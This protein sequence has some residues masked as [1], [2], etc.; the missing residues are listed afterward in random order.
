MAYE[1]TLIPIW[2]LITTFVTSAIT[3]TSEA[4]LGDYQVYIRPVPPLS[5]YDPAKFKQCFHNQ[6]I[7]HTL[8]D[9]ARNTR[10]EFD[11]W[12]P[13]CHRNLH[14]W[15]PVRRPRVEPHFGRGL[16]FLMMLRSGPTG[17]IQGLI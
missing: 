14:M 17:W 1:G 11:D 8:S 12:S 16:E 6:S 15:V 3:F 5:I 7:Q 4:E 10:L 9:A 2:S 13:Y